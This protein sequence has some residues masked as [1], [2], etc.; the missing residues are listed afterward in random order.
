MKWVQQ[1]QRIVLNEHEHGIEYKL[2]LQQT[3]TK[4][5]EIYQR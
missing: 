2:R 4:H 5:S 1:L 3:S